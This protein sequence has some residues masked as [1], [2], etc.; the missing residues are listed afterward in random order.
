ME[1]DLQTNINSE[2]SKIII[3]VL[4]ALLLITMIYIA[5]TEIPKIKNKKQLE[6]NQTYDLGYVA[7]INFWN[8]IVILTINT[9]NKIPYI[10][11]DSQVYKLNIDQMCEE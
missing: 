3:F 9:E 4:V 11:N 2:K 5:S 1:K 7:G 10:S 6:L 8:Q